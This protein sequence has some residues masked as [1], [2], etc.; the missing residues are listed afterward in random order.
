M[1]AEPPVDFTEI[2]AK[3]A[4]AGPFEVLQWAVERFFPRLTMATAFG[5]EGCAIIHM[6]A[7]I[8]PRVRVFNL[9][10]GYQFRETLDLRDRI[11]SRYGIEVEMVRPETTIEEY[12]S[13]HGGPL[14]QTHPDRCCHDR[15]ILPL[16]RAIQGYDAW[17]SSIRADQSNDRAATP[18]VGWDKK[19][20]LVKINPLLSWTKKDVWTFIV[21][22]NV[23]YNP[24]HDVGYPSIG[25]WPCTQPVTDGQDERAGRWAGKAKTECGLHSLD[26]SQL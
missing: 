3:L 5:A 7:E 17:I 2:N 15:K 6:L 12:E 10:T 14:Y 20:N 8:E 11:A 1:T 25:C 4:N 21:E 22:K 19:F 23:P 26:S 9:D 13:I 24:L 18:K 16:R